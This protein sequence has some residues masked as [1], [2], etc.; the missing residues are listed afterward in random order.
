MGGWSLED[1]FELNR[2]AFALHT[3]SYQMK[4]RPL[5][6]ES[7][8]ARLFARV[9][10]M[11]REQTSQAGGVAGA[12]AKAKP[13]QSLTPVGFRTAEEDAGYQQLARRSMGGNVEAHT[14][15]P[16][17]LPSA[18]L[19]RVNLVYRTAGGV[20]QC[21]YFDTKGGRRPYE[22]PMMRECAPLYNRREE[23][24]VWLWQP[25][26]GTGAKP[27]GGF[28]RPSFTRTSTVYCIGLQP[29]AVTPA[30]LE[31]QKTKA[32]PLWFVTCDPNKPAQ[33]WIA[34]PHEGGGVSAPRS[35]RSPPAALPFSL[36]LSLSLC[37]SLSLCLCLSLHVYV[38]VCA[39]VWWRPWWIECG[40]RFVP[41][42][43][44]GML[45]ACD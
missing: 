19:A 38:Y 21:V 20:D 8:F 18:P 28:L 16:P 15:D 13:P 4:Q 5:D 40:C 31:A 26:Q 27:K 2:G 25:G 24:A 41:A 6:P 11:A 35:N 36:F 43:S 14:P 7:H 30:A 10:E 37:P 29:K 33:R 9:G 12:D 23:R 34:E 22:L 45:C 17:F 42:C 39:C 3:R 44:C 32:I 1:A